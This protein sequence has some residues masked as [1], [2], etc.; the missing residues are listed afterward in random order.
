MPHVVV[1]VDAGG[2]TTV[3]A[4]S[5]DGEVLR[6]V[7]GPAANPSICGVENAGS[8]IG[9]LIVSA[10]DGAL[11]HAIFVGAAGAG[12]DDVA[13]A[14]CSALES[15]F[16]G[17]RVAVRDDAYIAL[18]AAVPQGDGAV[19]VAGTGS[20][21]FAIRGGEEFRSGGYGY[22]LGDDG[23]G[24]A[25]GSAALRTVLRA[26][27]DRAPRDEFVQTLI[28]ELGTADS[29]QILSRVHGENG[30]VARVSSLAPLVLQIANG[31]DRTANRIVQNAALELGDLAKSLVKRAGLTESGAPLVLAG[32]LLTSN[33]LLTF[34]LETRLKNDL[35][36]M[37][38]FKSAAEPYAGA[39]TAAQAL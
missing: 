36:S 24:F 20:I 39:L 9:D 35:P 12:R 30:G 23:S 17:A 2:T 28:D 14:I 37:P 3:A 7:S 27:D 29:S 13:S 6:T 31:G 15:R 5:Q 16:G 1:G 11:P 26:L 19:I 8:I 38:V 34:L 4:L 22:L 32:S 18:R 21:G 10:L 25:I 33:S